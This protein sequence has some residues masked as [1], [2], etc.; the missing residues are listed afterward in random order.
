MSSIN[1]NLGEINTAI[2]TLTGITTLHSEQISILQATDVALSTS[3]TG[4]T[5]TTILLANDKVNKTSFDGISVIYQ[6]DADNIQL[7][8]NST[9][10][11]ETSLLS[12]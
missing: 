4:L 5:A 2:G 8:Y 12:G 7:K 1:T 3:I 6:D 9:H 10:F 11:S